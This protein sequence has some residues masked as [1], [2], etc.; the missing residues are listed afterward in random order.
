[1]LTCVLYTVGIHFE[2]STWWF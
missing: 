1:M 2:Y